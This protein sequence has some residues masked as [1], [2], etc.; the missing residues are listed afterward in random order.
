MLPLPEIARSRGTLP[1]I[2]TVWNTNT[3]RR[4]ILPVDRPHSQGSAQTDRTPSLFPSPLQR[5]SPMLRFPGS[6]DDVPLFIPRLLMSRYVV[7]FRNSLIR[8]LRL[9][10]LNTMIKYSSS[11]DRTFQAL[12]DPIRRTMLTRFLQGP[13]TVNDWPA[14]W[15]SRFRLSCSTSLDARRGWACQTKIRARP[16]LPH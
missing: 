5:L 2:D 8:E 9:L 13:T 11:L 12:T 16:D 1:G 14:P 3:G 7:V 4:K 6:Q 15:E 10:L